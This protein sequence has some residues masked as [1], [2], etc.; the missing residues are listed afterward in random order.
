MAAKAKEPELP[1]ADCTDLLKSLDIRL[2]PKQQLF[3]DKLT[4]IG[5]VATV[6]GMGGSRGAAKSGGIRRIAIMLACTYKEV[7]IFVVRRVLGD[8]LLNH[9]AEMTLDYPEIH[10]LYHAPSGGKRPEYRFPNGSLVILIYAETL[11]DVER[12]VKGQQAAFVLIDQAEQFSEEELIAFREINRAPGVPEGFCKIGYFFNTAQGVGKAYFRRIFHTKRWR[13]NENP[14]TYDFM[15]VY[16]W[17]NYEWFRGQTPYTFEEF[18]QLSSEDRF[19]IF[20]RDTSQ[21]RKQNELSKRKRDADLLGNFDSGGGLYFNDVWG[22]YCTLDAQIAESLI[23][24][25]WTRWMAQQWGFGDPA[26]HLWAATGLVTP[27]IWK[28]TFG[29]T[30]PVPMECVIIYREL[31]DRKSST[32][33]LPVGRA[34]ADIAADIIAAT[35]EWERPSI[36]EFRLGSASLDQQKKRVEN[37]VGDGLGKILQRYGLPSPVPADESRVDGWRFM[38]ACLRQSELREATNISLEEVQQG[39]ALF[40]SSACPLCIE[41]IPLAPP[42]K[43]DLNDIEAEV[44]EVSSVV[45]AVRFLLKSKPSA[46]TQAPLAVR[47]QMALEAYTDPTAK[48]MAMLRFN[49][50]EARRGVSGRA[51]NWRQ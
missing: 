25:W 20:I 48:H 21:G 46:K 41:N 43:K 29:G 44:G 36:S 24:P 14:K 2:Q 47:R 49:E 16:G 22:D 9:V 8:L 30:I 17:D 28:Q 45:D 11:A 31:H 51:P 15:Q 6:L 23:Q 32:P 27:A 34:E 33:S 1:V 5:N 3:Y 38:Y 7:R 40:I 13:E 35:P 4:D 42:C 10:K 19:T 26:C 50:Q 12:L 37:T 39:A 18:Y